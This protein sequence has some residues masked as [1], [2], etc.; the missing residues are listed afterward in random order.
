MR[1]KT[2]AGFLTAAIAVSP[3]AVWA[4][5]NAE[6]LGAAVAGPCSLVT[7]DEEGRRVGPNLT[8]C[9]EA[10]N[11]AFA[12]APGMNADE[13]ERIGQGFVTALSVPLPPN[14]PMPIQPIVNVFSQQFSLHLFRNCVPGFT[15]AMT[16]TLET[17]TAAMRIILV[18]STGLPG[19]YQRDRGN[20]MCLSVQANP[21]WQAQLLALIDAYVARGGLDFIATARAECIFAPPAP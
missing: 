16:P 17:C 14:P 6:A 15:A 18:A 13:L 7:W 8:P 5:A 9:T 1:I 10:I 20:G 12:A 4:Q 21:A 19:A 11:D 3:T 2:I